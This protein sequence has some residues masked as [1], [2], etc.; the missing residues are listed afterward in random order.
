[1]ILQENAVVERSSVSSW[2]MTWSYPV[3]DLSDLA[4]FMCINYWVADVNKAFT[5]CL[6]FSS[7]LFG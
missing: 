3:I 5:I 2:K 1:M 6:S 4:S 7:S